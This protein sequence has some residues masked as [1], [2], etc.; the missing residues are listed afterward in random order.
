MRSQFVF[1]SCC[2]LTSLTA[3]AQEPAPRH[4]FVNYTELGILTG[5][6]AYSF[7]NNPSEFVENK[8]SLTFQTF[9]GL[10][11]TQR[12]AVG[13]VVGVD[14]YGS[15]L[16]MPVGAGLR[17]DLVQPTQKNVRLFAMADAGYGFAW[18]HRASTGYEVAGGPM[19]NPGL[20]LALGRPGKAA[21]TMSLSYKR[22][23]ASVQKP[24]VGNDIRRDEERVYNRLAIRLGMSF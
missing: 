9:N 20:G 2:L 19:V 7:A 18:L 17:Y 11:L 1:L 23:A 10:Y 22:Q 6:V 16:L 5:R 24:I 15:A 13:G 8:F 12:L 14:W 21:F 3:Q 4:P